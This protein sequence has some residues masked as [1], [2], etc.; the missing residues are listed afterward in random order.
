MIKKLLERLL[1]GAGVY[2]CLA[3]AIAICII[4]FIILAVPVLIMAVV[5]PLVQ[6]VKANKRLKSSTR[7]EVI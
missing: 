3:I 5:K 7:K 1:I 6:W 2:I 4:G